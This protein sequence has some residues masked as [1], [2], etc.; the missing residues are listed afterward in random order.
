M[1][2]APPTPRP[3]TLDAVS[4]RYGSGPFVIRDLSAAF[5]PGAAVGLVGPNGSGK[6]TLL[7]MLSVLTRPTSGAVRYGDLDVHRHPRA[8]L[9][10]V[11]IVHDKAD[12]PGFLTAPELLEW[13]ARERGAWTDTSPAEHHALLDAVALDDRRAQPIGTY[14]SG[15]TRKTQIAAAFAARPS[16]L[17]F[18]EPFRA[19]DV[20]ATEAAVGGLVAF[21][22]AGGVVLLSSHR[23]DL[24]DR[25]VTERVVLG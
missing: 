10:H 7:K 12:L 15:M 19:L 6:S 20:E 22:D 23:A 17:L 2:L 8:Y 24:L 4:K 13:I 16:V 25:V 1:H 18:D 21:R 3:I 5:V 9:Q 11:G 14:S